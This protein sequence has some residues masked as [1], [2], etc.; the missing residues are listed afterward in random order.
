MPS[1]T[2]RAIRCSTTCRRVRSSRPGGLQQPF[3]RMDPHAPTALPLEAVSPERAGRAD[4]RREAEES[5][6]AR[7]GPEVA[8]LLPARAATG[9]GLQVQ[10]EVALR[11]PSAVLLGRHLG[12]QPPSG[13]GEHLP[14]L[15]I[16]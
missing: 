7:T 2:S 12:D 15:P 10:R 1:W 14:R 8:A 5:P 6:T 3:L 13:V 9:A 16:P 11:E 4:V